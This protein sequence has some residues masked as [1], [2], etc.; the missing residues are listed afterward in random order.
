MGANEVP[1]GQPPSQFERHPAAEFVARVD[2]DA[3]LVCTGVL[4]AT[5]APLLRHD[6]QRMLLVHPDR[7]VVDLAGVTAFGASAIGAFVQAR[8]ASRTAGGDL[9][10]RAP[11]P[12]GRRVLEMMGLPEL[13][14][15]GPDQD[16]DVSEE[17]SHGVHPTRTATELDVAWRQACESERYGSAPLALDP[18]LIVPVIAALLDRA[19]SPAPDTLVADDWVSIALAG[20]QVSATALL[21]LWALS[22]LVQ[23]RIDAGRGSEA[24]HDNQA[25]QRAAVEAVLAGLA[26]AMLNELEQATLLDPLTGL[27]NRRALDRDLLHALAVASR[28]GHTLSVVMID[29]VGLKSINDHFG[30]AAGDII[31]REVATN[32]TSMLRA[33]DQAYRVGGDEFV[34]LL[35]EMSPHDIQAVL[36]RAIGAAHAPCTWGC[37][38]MAEDDATDS[39]ATERAHRLL[40]LADQRMIE[41]RNRRQPDPAEHHAEAGAAAPLISPRTK[42]KLA[43]EFAVAGRASA[44][45]EEAKGLVAGHFDISIDEATTMLHLFSATQPEPLSATATALVDGTLEPALLALHRPRSAATPPGRHDPRDSRRSTA[46]EG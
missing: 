17:E 6:L 43:G 25:R 45:V 38:S 33:D 5:T 3:V 9:V 39:A 26:W 21:Q 40:A 37:A 34:L 28:H 23:A 29:V 16:Q 14:E 22:D 10:L 13:I 1:D 24:G 27:L 19:E 44:L 42:V 2:G 8:E 7:V 41:F 15:S 35:P 32:L 4:D 18:S 46:T 30:H 12:L 31:L 20:S 11:S 36:G